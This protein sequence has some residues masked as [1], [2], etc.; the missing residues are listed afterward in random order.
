M[1]RFASSADSRNS[2]D[3]TAAERHHGAVPTLDDLTWPVPTERLSLRRLGDSDVADTW[4]YRRLP[5]VNRWLPYAPADLDA[6]AEL[7]ADADRSPDLAVVHTPRHRFL[8]EGGWVPVVQRACPTTGCTGDPTRVHTQQPAAGTVERDHSI[9]TIV[10]EPEDQPAP[11]DTTSPSE[12]SPSPTATAPDRLDARDGYSVASV[13]T[14]IWLGDL[15]GAADR[16]RPF[17]DLDL[18]A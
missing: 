6:Y 11:E 14:Q 18:S 10:L 4:A 2:R 12:P 9:V 3:G 13:Q 1:R 15:P 8:E 7:F 16:H 17:H 5:E